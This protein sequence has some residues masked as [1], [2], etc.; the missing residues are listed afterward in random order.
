ME[1][2]MKQQQNKNPLGTLPVPKL[3]LKFSVPSII[4]MLTSALYNMVDQYF[5]GNSVG[6]LGNARSEERRVG[7]EC[8]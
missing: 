5:I 8:L 3:L 4:A 7:K 6:E 2:R 1:Q